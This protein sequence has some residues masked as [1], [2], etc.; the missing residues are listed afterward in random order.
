MLR[1]LALALVGALALSAHLPAH[2]GVVNGYSFATPIVSSFCS[3]TTATSLGLSTC[4]SGVPAG[5]LC[6]LVTATGAAINWRDDGTAATASVGTGGQ[7]LA[8]N[9]SM[10]YCGTLA[11]LRFIQ[12]GATG[13]LS[14]SFYQ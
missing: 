11:T 13:I 5:A 2:A 7:P 14:V 8:Q 1:R 4:G 12:Q 9:A 3:M 6:A 10:W